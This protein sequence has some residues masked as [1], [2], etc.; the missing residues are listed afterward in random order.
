VKIRTED[1]GDVVCMSSLVFKPYCVKWTCRIIIGRGWR[2]KI[3]DLPMRRY[4]G[5]AAAAEM[6][7]RDLLGRRR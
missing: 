5:N 6:F 4:F 3:M 2:P 7:R 1:V